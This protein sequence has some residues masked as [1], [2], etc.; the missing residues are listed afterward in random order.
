MSYAQQ[1]NHLSSDAYH[2]DRKEGEVFFHRRQDQNDQMKRGQ[3]VRQK[4]L[5]LHLQAM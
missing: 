4:Q 3:H 2:P 1:Y 5:P